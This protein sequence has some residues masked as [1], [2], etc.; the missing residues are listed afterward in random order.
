MPTWICMDSDNCDNEICVHQGR[1]LPDS[2]G[3]GEGK[4]C[5]IDPQEVK[6]ILASKKKEE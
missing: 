1:S 2:V 6:R 3:C 4:W 5:I